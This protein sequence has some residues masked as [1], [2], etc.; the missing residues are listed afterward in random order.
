MLETEMR[1]GKILS[2]EAVRTRSVQRHAIKRLGRGGLQR[3]L[4]GE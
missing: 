2:T 4:S 3:G 1:Y